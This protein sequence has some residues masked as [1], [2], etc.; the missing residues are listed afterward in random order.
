MAAAAAASSSS[1]SGAEVESGMTIALESNDGEIFW[2]TEASARQSKLIEDLIDSGI[3]HPYKL[4]NVDSE[5]LKAVIEYCDEHGNNNP[6]TDEERK[7]RKDFDVGFRGKLDG[8]KG[9]LNKVIK[10]AKYL[11]I[12]GLLEEI[13]EAFNIPDGRTAFEYEAPKDKRMI[14]LTSKEGE[15]FLVTEASAR[16]SKLI[17]GMIDSGFAHPYKLP[18]VDSETLKAVI[19]YCDEHGN[20]NP[21]TEEERKARKDFDVGFRGKLDG[22]K[23]LLIKVIMAAHYL[24][25]EGLITTT[26]RNTKAWDNGFAEV[27]TGDG[28][29]NIHVLLDLIRK[30]V[31]DALAHTGGNSLSSSEVD[32]LGEFRK[33]IDTYLGEM[34]GQ[35]DF[36]GLMI[37]PSIPSH[38]IFV[39]AVAD[40]VAELVRSMYVYYILRTRGVDAI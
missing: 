4:P 19:E 22:D 35:D 38:H 28:D 5:M 12:E 26:R 36:L 34:G 29:L 20:N 32:I 8:D 33:K 10:A 1:S 13:R 11:S 18:N 23:D 17:E 40:G 37:N 39:D 9:L 14:A 15:L 25:I 16:Q 27:I 24:D 7:A 30:R 31:V 6:A 2:V 21:A 3:N